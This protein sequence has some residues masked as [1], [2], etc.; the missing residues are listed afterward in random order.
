MTVRP[1]APA[2]LRAIMGEP[3][4]DEQCRRDMETATAGF[5]NKMWSDFEADQRARHP[6]VYA[7]GERLIREREAERGGEHI[8]RGK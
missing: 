4:F 6:D 8:G 2:T 1:I 3:S 5:I 7:L